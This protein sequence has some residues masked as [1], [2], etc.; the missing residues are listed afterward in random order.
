MFIFLRLTVWSH[1]H[2][3]PIVSVHNGNHGYHAFTQ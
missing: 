1:G 2:L 3:K